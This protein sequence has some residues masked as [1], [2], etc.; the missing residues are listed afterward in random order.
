M[1]A[2]QEAR[3]DKLKEMREK[4]VKKLDESKKEIGRLDFLIEQMEKKQLPIQRDR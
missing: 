3:L 2:G 1:D 4:E